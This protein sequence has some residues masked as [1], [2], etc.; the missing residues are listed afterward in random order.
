MRKVL[1]LPGLEKR[2][3]NDSYAA[4]LVEQGKA[5]Y[6]VESAE[7]EPVVAEVAEKP[8]AKRH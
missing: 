2:E 4:R 1:M 8:K 6:A 7:K 3:Y 5:V